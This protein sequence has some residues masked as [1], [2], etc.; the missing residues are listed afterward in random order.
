MRLST[1][2]DQEE[3]ASFKRYMKEVKYNQRLMEDLI[4]RYYH[5][6]T[7]EMAGDASGVQK[8]LQ[9]AKTLDLSC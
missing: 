2:E 8:W 3:V 4:D 7:K 5:F 1:T 9:R 6:V